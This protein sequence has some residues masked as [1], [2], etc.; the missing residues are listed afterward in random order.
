MDAKIR[1]LQ[2]NLIYSGM[3]VVLFSVWPFLRFIL[4]ELIS[5]RS[6]FDGIDMDVEIPHFRAIIYAILFVLFIINL[7]IHLYI[8]RCA[9]AEGRGSL[10]NS[11]AY[12]IISSIFL[13]IY[14]SSIISTLA[15]LKESND[16]ST[17]VTSI[18]VELTSCWIMLSIIISAIALRRI[19][20]IRSETVTN[21]EGL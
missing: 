19:T 10:Q 8:A 3:G 17:D 4:V 1:R 21:E 14:I 5:P 18:I 11:P 7:F 2:S 16:F 13:I 15:G 20:A 12:I 9:V 6:I